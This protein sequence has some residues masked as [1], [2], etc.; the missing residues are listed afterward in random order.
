MSRFKWIRRREAVEKA[1]EI[2]IVERLFPGEAAMRFLAEASSWY[3]EYPNE[4]SE[5]QLARFMADVKKQVAQ[6]GLILKDQKE[7]NNK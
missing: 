5:L 3:C 2:A 1:A 7:K 4:M 6:R